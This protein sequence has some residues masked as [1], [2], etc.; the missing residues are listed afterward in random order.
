M[1][2]PS[3]RIRPE[4]HLSGWHGSYRVLPQMAALSSAGRQIVVPVALAAAAWTLLVARLALKGAEPQPREDVPARAALLAATV[5]AAAVAVSLVVLSYQS[6]PA[7]LQT[8]FAGGGL[9]GEP[10]DLLRQWLVLGAGSGPAG[11][12]LGDWLL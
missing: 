5:G 12:P 1:G 9:L 11:A 6:N 2:T 4:P 7:T 3:D 8:A 10:S